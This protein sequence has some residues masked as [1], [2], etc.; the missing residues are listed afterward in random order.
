MIWSTRELATYCGLL[1]QYCKRWKTRELA[2]YCGSVL[3]FQRWNKNPQYCPITA[4]PWELRSAHKNMSCESIRALCRRHFTCRN[5]RN[6]V[7]RLAGSQHGWKLLGSSWDLMIFEGMS[8]ESFSLWEFKL[9]S[10]YEENRLITLHRHS[11]RNFSPAPDLALWKLIF[12]HAYFSRGVFCSQTPVF[13][14]TAA[15]AI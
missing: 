15:Q 13:M 4:P 10:Q 2:K 3:S 6:L 12:P 5:P 8:P 7:Q 1:F 11:G 9:Q 14:K